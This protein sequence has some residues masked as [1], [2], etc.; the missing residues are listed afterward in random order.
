MTNSFSKILKEKMREKGLTLN[1]LSKLTGISKSS[2]HAYTIGTQPVMKNLIILARFF[3]IP[4]EDFVEDSN[5]SLSGTTK[6]VTIQVES[7]IFE[8]K[9]KKVK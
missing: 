6:T 9:I 2:L 3:Q 5:D 1:A 7:N 4:I 8:I